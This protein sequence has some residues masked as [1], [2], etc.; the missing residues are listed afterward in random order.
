MRLE[1]DSFE[2]IIENLIKRADTFLYKS[3]AA[4][5]N[6]LTIG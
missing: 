2:R 5:R 6:C 4:G 3:K 1:K